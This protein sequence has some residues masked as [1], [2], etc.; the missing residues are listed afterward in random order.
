MRVLLFLAGHGEKAHKLNLRELSTIYM[1]EQNTTRKSNELKHSK[2]G[3]R[4]H[5]QKKPNEE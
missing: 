1:N 4:Q 2:G 5:I 3:E